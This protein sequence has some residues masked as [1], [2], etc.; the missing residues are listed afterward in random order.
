MRIRKY[1]LGTGQKRLFSIDNSSKYNVPIIYTITKRALKMK[2]KGKS[3]YH[4]SK[5]ALKKNAETYRKEKKSSSTKTWK[6]FMEA[7]A[8]L[9]MKCLLV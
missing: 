5:R 3:I 9:S 2:K 7:K 6:N 1:S 8:S 4:L